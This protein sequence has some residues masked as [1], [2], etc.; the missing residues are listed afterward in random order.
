MPIP[1]VGA[2]EFLIILIAALLIFGPSKL[3]EI[4]GQAGK[5]LREL[6]KMTSSLTTDFE[7]SLNEAAGTDVRKTLSQELTGIKNEV[8]GV[9][10]TVHSTVNTGIG[11]TGSKTTSTR[12]TTT[13]TATG[14]TTTR[15][16]TTVKPATS[17]SSRPA[18]A[19]SKTTTP[20]KT[21]T[22]STTSATSTAGRTLA[23][24]VEA[25]APPPV[26]SKVDPLSDVSLLDDALLA[27]EKPLRRGRSARTG[28][29]ATKVTPA[30]P[31]AARSA[32]AQP[33]AVV[34]QPLPSAEPKVKPPAN[35]D[36]LALA[37]QKTGSAYQSA[38]R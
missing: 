11:A 37:R 32:P 8:E 16:A 7:K 33:I 10:K 23:K 5:G 14:T 24:A 3:P 15:T 38:A 13:R 17:A 29:T 4:M 20:A 26:A 35:F 34:N 1:G 30:K 2:P 9:G 28:T 25:P 36:P 21:T 12:T 19:A 31:A 18:T 6:R 27:P 22:G